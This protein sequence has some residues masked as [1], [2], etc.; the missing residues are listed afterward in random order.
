VFSFRHD[1][2][3]PKYTLSDTL[4]P[5]RSEYTHTLLTDYANLDQY[6]PQTSFGNV[7]ESANDANTIRWES[8]PTRPVKLSTLEALRKGKNVK[9]AILLLQRKL[10]IEIPGTY[11]LPRADTIFGL[12]HTLDYLCLTP[13]LPGFSV[14]LPPDDYIPSNSWEFNLDLSRP[15]KTLKVKVRIHVKFSIPFARQLF[16]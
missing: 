7:P 15:L 11:T 6:L 2:L 13:C 5:Q 1:Q 10:R 4:P 14:I 9:A 12:S 3:T 8:I 16:A